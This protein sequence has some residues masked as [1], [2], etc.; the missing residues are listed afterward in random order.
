MGQ[1][2]ICEASLTNP[3]ISVTLPSFVQLLLLLL[4][5]GLGLV[6]RM[7]EGVISVAEVLM[8]CEEGLGVT[9][10]TLVL[11]AVVRLTSLGYSTVLDVLV[12]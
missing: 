8:R 3:L 12:V 9:T 10:V 11:V 5:I 7:A 6:G 4:W 2:V 1:L